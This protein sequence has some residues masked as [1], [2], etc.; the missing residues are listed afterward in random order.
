M[1]RLEGLDFARSLA[2]L[3]MML[4]NYSLVFEAGG[5]KWLAQV[6]TL[7]EGRAAAVFLILAGI[8]IS[9][10]TRKGRTTGDKIIQHKERV[11]IA[12]R[13]IFLW[14][15]GLILF[16][17]F[18]WSADILHYYGAYMLLML[19]I[20]YWKPKNIKK[21]MILVLLVSGYLQMTFDYNAGWQS[22]FMAYTDFWTLSGFF[23]NLF[24]N[25]FHPIFPWFTFMLFGFTI[26]QLDLTDRPLRKKFLVYGFATAIITELTS[27]GL[28]ALT[29]NTELS[30]Y[31][32]GT[33]PM[34]PSLF[35]IFA[36]SGWA[37]C[38]IILCLSLIDRFPESCWIQAMIETG[39]MALT[40]YIFHSAFVLSLMFILGLITQQ[41]SVFVL[42]LSLTV[43]GIMICF[44]VLWRFKFQ[45]GPFETLMRLISDTRESKARVNL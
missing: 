8:G 27:M 13:S 2:I 17:V 14:V 11:T 9:L 23:R 43:Y 7:F 30:I 45:R 44:S 10:M 26:G 25:G 19:P 32:F 22:D 42:L 41:S 16:T 34:P 35:Y 31:L 5:P 1:K 36:A 12:K 3:G 37:I 4:V 28:I 15:I 18:E 40:H 39:Q 33:K 20:L 24:F 21:L 29:G 6:F 38:W